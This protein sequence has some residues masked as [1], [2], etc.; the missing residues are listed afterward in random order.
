M[1]VNNS[2]ESRIISD[3]RKKTI[4]FYTNGHNHYRDGKQCG[5]SPPILQSGL[6]SSYF[7]NSCTLSASLSLND[8]GPQYTLPR[9][10]GTVVALA[11][12]ESPEVLGRI[13]V[14]RVGNDAPF[15][16]GP[17]LP[18]RPASALCLGKGLHLYN[19]SDGVV[20]TSHEDAPR[21]GLA[22]ENDKRSSRHIF[23]FVLRLPFR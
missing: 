21:G 4:L 6:S 1:N 23:P 5:K 18:R 14:C 16:E 12:P 8:Y 15:Q 19:L 2:K 20:K 10:D 17:S 3:N 22:L 9:R 13:R 11:R 7:N